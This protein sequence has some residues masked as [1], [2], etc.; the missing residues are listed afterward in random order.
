MANIISLFLGQKLPITIGAILGIAL[1]ILFLIFILILIC[2]KTH[3]LLELRAIFKRRVLLLVDCGKDYVLTDVEDDNAGILKGKKHYWIKVRESLKPERS[4]G[5]PFGVALVEKAYAVP[6]FLA[7]LTNKGWDENKSLFSDVYYDK[8]TGQAVVKKEGLDIEAQK[9]GGLLKYFGITIPFD[10]VI[11][12]FNSLSPAALYSLVQ[13]EVADEIQDIH[14][15]NWNVVFYVVMFMIGI[16]ITY[17][18]IRGNAP[19]VATPQ[20]IMSNMSSVK[21]VLLG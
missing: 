18:I 16:A 15:F 21:N 10:K 2:V 20:I 14:K 11:Y 17:L 5:I 9:N 12:L 7:A 8:K 13:R 4:K 1:G 19:A 6:T 3:A